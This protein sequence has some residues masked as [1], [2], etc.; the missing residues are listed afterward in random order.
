MVT[1]AGRGLGR[2]V[3]L[4]LAR[5][6]WD[7]AL[8]ARTRSQLEAVAEEVRALGSRAEVFPATVDHE[9]SVHTAFQHFQERFQRLDALVHCAGAGSFAPIAE[10]G[11]AEWERVLG[12]NLTGTYLCCRHALR[13]M[14]PQGSGQIVNVLSIAAKVAF[15][16]AAA[17]CASK[18]GALGFTKVLAEEARGHGIRV[19]A[20][21]PGSI[22]TPF[23]DSV[24]GAPFDR[25]DML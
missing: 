4:E 13:I 10:L 3:S 18:W 14:E 7:L 19:T 17:Y 11:A 6:G 12:A 16:G 20:L 21:C 9:Q 5:H 22:D 1:G 8:L 2:A 25:A 24:G 15:P 23:W